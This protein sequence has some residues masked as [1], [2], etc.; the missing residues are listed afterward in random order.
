MMRMIFIRHGAKRSKG[1]ELTSYG[2]KMSFQSGQWLSHNGYIPARGFHTPTA[3]TQQTLE[4]VLLGCERTIQVQQIEIG[5]NW[6]GWLAMLEKI[7][8]AN[9]SDVVV[10]GHHPTTEMLAQHYNIRIPTQ[11]FATAIVLQKSSDGLWSFIDS[12]QGQTAIS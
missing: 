3:R 2:R 1:G 5:E 6:Q 10:V 7:S 4:E 12:W 8:K 11:N 9:T